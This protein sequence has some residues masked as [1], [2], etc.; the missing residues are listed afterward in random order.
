[1]KLSIALFLILAFASAAFTQPPPPP[2][3][4]CFFNVLQNGSFTNGVTI[5][6]N[7]AGSIPPSSVANWN[8]AFGNPQ[9]V[10]A[11]GCPAPDFIAMWGNQVVGE[12]LRQTLAAPL[13]PGKKYSFSACVRYANPSAAGPVRFKVRASAGP[14]PNYIAPGQ[15]IGVTANI[16]S[17][18]WT[19]ITLA[20]W[21]A[22]VAGLNTITIN[23][24]NQLAVNDGT[25]V[26][27]GHIDN[28]CL[29]PVTAPC[30]LDP[31]M[32]SAG[33]TFA[34]RATLA[35]TFTPPN[36]GGLGTINHGLQKLSSSVNSYQLL[37]TTTTNNGLPSWT[38]GSTAVSSTVLYS[39]TY[40]SNPTDWATNAQ[41]NATIQIGW[42]NPVWLTAGKKY[43]LILIPGAPASGLMYWRGNSGAST[44]PN[45]SAYE[46]SGNTWVIPGT[47]PKDHG[48]KLAGNCHQ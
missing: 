11:G 43:A 29:K 46:L 48:F 3:G 47:G 5:V 14:L 38:G 15:L 22:P 1:M 18:N 10:A 45:G 33:N 35:Q 27:W 16:S 26:S 20:N 28:V 37:I 44:Y 36:S 4:P 24:E 12:A 9:I 40:G 30:T 17:T 42:I 13:T 23:P 31:G 41:V 19:N 8:A 2:P 32:V 7:S 21:T 6:P 25:K 34:R 39:A